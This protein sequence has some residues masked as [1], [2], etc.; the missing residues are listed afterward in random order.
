LAKIQLIFDGQIKQEYELNK[1]EMFI[2]RHASNDI[3]IENRGV[4]GKHAVIQT[5][6]DKFIIKDLESTNG[7]KLNGKKIS[8]AELTH[9]D[10]INLFKHTLNFVLVSS[11]QSSSV[12]STV[13]A[14]SAANVDPDSTIM[15]DANHID[16][17]V[18]G[19]KAEKKEGTNKSSTTQP[20]LEVTSAEGVN[21]ITLSNKAI[22][23]GKK[24]SCDIQ[25][26]GW[27][28]TPAISAVIKKD[29]SGMYIIKPETTIKLNNKKVK[30]KHILKNGDQILI[31]NTVIIFII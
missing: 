25:T 8:S 3:V 19:Y 9:G 2:G 7:T 21:T 30:N 23:I 16:K 5:Q 18:S 12:E 10:H 1:A 27:F 14:H 17:M 13:P 26:G 15:L 22:V 28:L 11:E 29:M 4:S 31:R 20:L 6:D 24:D